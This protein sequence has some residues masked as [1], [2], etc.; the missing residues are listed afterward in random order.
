VITGFNNSFEEDKM[1]SLENMDD[2]RLQEATAQMKHAI[3]PY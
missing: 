1:D 3:I 2:K